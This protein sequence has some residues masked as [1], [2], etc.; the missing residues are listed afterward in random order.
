MINPTI[1]RYDFCRITTLPFVGI[2]PLVGTPIA[3]ILLV[4]LV[5]TPVAGTP[6]AG[7]LLVLLVGTPIAGILLVPLV[8]IPNFGYWEKNKKVHFKKNC[9]H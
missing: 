8:G 2:L 9:S 4:L 7:I 5:G 3:G 6:V 1:L